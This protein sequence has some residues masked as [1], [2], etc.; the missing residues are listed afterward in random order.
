MKK[1]ATLLLA[2]GALIAA[3]GYSFA[4]HSDVGGLT[5]PWMQDDPGFSE[6]LRARKNVDKLRPSAN[7]KK[8]AHWGKHH[9]HGI[10]LE[11]SDHPSRS[12][13]FVYD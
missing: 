10:Y 5:V 3:T 13:T 8:G 11:G 2:S 9:H 4:D 1:T 12:E 6:N 7:I